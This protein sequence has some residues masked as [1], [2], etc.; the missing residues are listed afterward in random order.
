[1]AVVRLMFEGESRNVFRF[2]FQPEKPVSTVFNGI[3]LSI[4]GSREASN[5]ESVDS[6][7]EE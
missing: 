5:N 6:D 3:R 7:E 4:I 1:M 2:Q